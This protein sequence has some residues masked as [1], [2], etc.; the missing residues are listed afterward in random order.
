AFEDELNRR[1]AEWQR[2]GAAFTL[3]AIEIDNFSR[4]A[5][6]TDVDTVNPVLQDIAHALDATMREMDLVARYGPGQFALLLPATK[7]PEATRAAERARLAIEATCA[8]RAD[9][10]LHASVGV[11]EAQ[12]ADNGRSLLRRATS[13]LSVAKEAGGQ[14][15]YFHDGSVSHPILNSSSNSPALRGPE[16][17]AA[18]PRNNHYAQY[19][20]ALNV[21]ARTDV[22]TGLPNRRAFSDEIRRA[23]VESHQNGRPLSL[24]VVG[25]DNLSRLSSRQG[26][27][28]VDQV[29]R[30]MAQVICAMVRDT[31]L[32]T[33]YGWEE[34][35]IILPGTTLREATNAS[36]R[37]LTALGAC[38]VQLDHAADVTIS[39]GVT[40]LE[41]D[42]D[43]VSLC[44]RA[45]EQLQAAR[46]NGL[47]CVRFHSPDLGDM[48]LPLQ[49]TP[50]S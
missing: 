9:L 16:V 4:I 13:A 19:V 49:P 33:R 21:D 40:T 44:R 7:L 8:K 34:F 24:L 1:F 15:G 11:A 30:K 32:V 46:L 35:A 26:Q 25:I 36:Q 43:A 27:G 47:Q 39:S 50:M 48:I 42:D 6:E 12:A 23:V 28:A 29:L 18:A 37:V 10:R 14:C 45:D 31:D 22:L 17:P 20:A 41:S 38:E 2:T 5:Q 3:V